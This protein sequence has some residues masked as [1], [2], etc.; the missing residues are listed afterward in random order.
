MK[1]K[2]VRA[3]KYIRKEVIIHYKNEK[4]PESKDPAT[5]LEIYKNFFIVLHKSEYISWCRQSE[6]VQVSSKTSPK[7]T[8]DKRKK[9]FAEQ[10][11]TARSEIDAELEELQKKAEEEK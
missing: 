9:D 10:V 2:E 3:S 1:P 6:I 11:Q 8:I 5:V 4:E 7:R